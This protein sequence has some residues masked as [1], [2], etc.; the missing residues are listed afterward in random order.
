MKDYSLKV[1]YTNVRTPLVIV[2]L[3]IAILFGSCGNDNFENSPI[4]P[5]SHTTSGF[6]DTITI[7]V[8]N[9]VAFDSVVTSGREIGFSGLYYDQYI[10]SIKTQTY[11]RLGRLSAINNSINTQKIKISWNRRI[12]INSGRFT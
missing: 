3:F 4:I 11:I 1:F 10:G 2:L 7:K 9:L 6:I 5:Q 12:V 8:S